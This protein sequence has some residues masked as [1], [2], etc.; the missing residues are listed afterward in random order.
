MAKPDIVI[1]DGLPSPA[2]LQVWMALKN[3]FQEKREARCRW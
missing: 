2:C 3:V 1:V